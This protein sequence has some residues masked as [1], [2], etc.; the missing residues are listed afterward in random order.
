[1]ARSRLLIA[2]V[3]GPGRVSSLRSFG[4]GRLWHARWPRLQTLRLSL[5]LP[6]RK[7][8]QSWRNVRKRRYFVF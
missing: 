1:M 4:V 8:G 7:E 3:R 6:L 2:F 5:Q